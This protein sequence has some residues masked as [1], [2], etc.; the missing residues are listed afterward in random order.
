[1]VNKLNDISFLPRWIILL[2][3]LGILL[4]AIVFAYLLRFN[5]NV[6]DVLNF[7]FQEGLI[8]FTICHLLAILITQSYAGIIRYT[9]I[10]DGFRISYTTLI[11]AVLAGIVS[12]VH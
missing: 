11:G 4:A 2:I 8:L 5:F 9:S 6:E 3:D 10:Q 12:Y 1:M 7:K